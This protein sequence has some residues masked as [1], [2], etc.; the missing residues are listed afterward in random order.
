MMPGFRIKITGFSFSYYKGRT[1]ISKP[2]DRVNVSA[3]QTSALA[4]NEDGNYVKSG[5]CFFLLL[6]TSYDF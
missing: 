2:D 4:G 3:T 1:I 6:T 5:A